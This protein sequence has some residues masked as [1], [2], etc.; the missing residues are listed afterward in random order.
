L[1]D[2]PTYAERIY[3]YEPEV[4][5]GFSVPAFYGKGMRVCLLLNGRVT[6]KLRCWVKGAMT[7][8]FD[9][10][11]IGSGNNSIQGQIRWD[12]TIQ[13]MLNL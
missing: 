10:Q 2:I 7:R 11:V 9:R 3:T 6:K 4:L 5:Y 8:Y 1:F 12:L 13:L